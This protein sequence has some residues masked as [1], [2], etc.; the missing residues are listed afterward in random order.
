MLDQA[1]DQRHESIQRRWQTV[2]PHNSLEHR[3][4]LVLL[5]SLKT[6][7]RGAYRSQSMCRR[8][9]R[10]FL[11][12]EYCWRS[13]MIHQLTLEGA[14]RPRPSNLNSHEQALSSQRGFVEGDIGY[15]APVAY[16]K[17]QEWAMRQKH[18]GCAISPYVLEHLPS[19]GD[20]LLASASRADWSNA[21]K[22]ADQ[23]PRPVPPPIEAW[24]VVRGIINRWRAIANTAGQDRENSGEGPLWR[25]CR[26]LQ[27]ST[28]LPGDKRCSISGRL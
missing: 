9:S 14:P 7:R 12:E 4:R 15:P 13:T 5:R 6:A 19:G 21:R 25:P 22:M 3:I 2:S 27:S 18:A 8:W 20:P 11:S 28:P 16:L 17:G 26:G 24:K 1:D 10:P 23:P